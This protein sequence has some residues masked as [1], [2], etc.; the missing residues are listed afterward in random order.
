MQVKDIKIDEG[1]TVNLPQ[2]Q[3]VAL[4]M[5]PRKEREEVVAVEGAVEGAPAEG[6]AAE[7]GEGE[8]EAKAE[9]P[10]KKEKKDRDKR[11]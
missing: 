11:E 2:N 5:A 7:G 1:V 10:E 6:E 4:V 8:G 3:T 9:K